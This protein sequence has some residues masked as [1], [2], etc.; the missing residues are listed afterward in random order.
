MA[1]QEGHGL[2][3]MIVRILAMTPKK[4]FNTSAHNTQLLPSSDDETKDHEDQNNSACHG[5][6]CNYNNRILLTGY[7]SCCE[8]M[9]NI[10]KT[11]TTIKD[12]NT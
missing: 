12:T 6:Y 4:C 3:I 9:H 11:Q 1:F 10:I 2:L 5:N 8:K 7:S